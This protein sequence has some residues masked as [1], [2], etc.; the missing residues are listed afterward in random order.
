MKRQNFSL[1]FMFLSKKVTIQWSVDKKEKRAYMDYEKKQV[2]FE[3][4]QVHFFKK[5]L[6]FFSVVEVPFFQRIN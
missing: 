4:K 1:F 2:H 5:V 3:K 6:V